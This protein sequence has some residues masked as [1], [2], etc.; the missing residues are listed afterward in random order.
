M[1]SLEGAFSVRL[2]AWDARRDILPCGL[3]LIRLMSFTSNLT[4][5][6]PIDQLFI[7]LQGLTPEQQQGIEHSLEQLPR[8]A[9]LASKSCEEWELK[10]SVCG[11]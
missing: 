9:K 1:V 3:Q 11:L 2:S 6:G 10:H 4:Q 5:V 8:A 7:S